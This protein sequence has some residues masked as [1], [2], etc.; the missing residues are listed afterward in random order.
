MCDYLTN[1]LPVYAGMVKDLEMR[2]LKLYPNR[3]HKDMKVYVQR[4]ILRRARNMID[5]KKLKSLLQQDKMNVNSLLL[6]HKSWIERGIHNDY[7]SQIEPYLLKSRTVLDIG[8]GFSPI[9]LLSRYRHFNDFCGIDSNR[10]VI[11]VLR[12]V[13]PNISKSKTS[14]I[15][16]RIENVSLGKIDFDF[17]FVQK[18]IPYLMKKSK[19]S[20]LQAI[21]N[22][23]TS[24]AFISCSKRSLSRP[25]SIIKE[26][27]SAI[28]Q[29]CSHK[30]FCIVDQFDKENEFGYVIKR[31]EILK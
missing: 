11:D 23:I 29:F 16:N 19:K 26:E 13:C 12:Y 10:S 20:S 21:Q 8:C 2:F 7:Y 27:K 15:A 17:V 30:I 3:T 9:Y 4:Q 28:E 18:L 5:K 14:F 24:Y 6:T 31:K 22:L 1:L 25:C